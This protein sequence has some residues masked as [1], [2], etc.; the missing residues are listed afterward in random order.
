M[1][2]LPSHFQRILIAGYYATGSGYPNG[3]ITQE[4]L[5][6]ISHVN[7][8]DCGYSMP[9]GT[10]L[11]ESIEK[12]PLAKMDVLWKLLTRNLY[13]A[14]TVLRVKKPG[15]I[16]YVRY[17]GIFFLL[18]MSLVPVKFRP[19]LVADA[20]IS[21]WESWS[22]NRAKGSRIFAK[23]LFS[24]E[25][26]ALTTCTRIIVDTTANPAYIAKTFSIAKEKIEAIP[27]GLKLVQS[28]QPTQN[29]STPEVTSVLFVGTFIPLHGIGVIIE[30]MRLLKSHGDF[31]FKFIGDGAE[32]YKLE[33]AIKSDKD[34]P[35][36]EWIRTWQSPSQL[37]EA[38]THSD[39]CLGIF[40]GDE[41]S[42][43]VLPYKL[44]IYMMLA[45]CVIS[46]SNYSLPA[47]IQ[48]HLPILKVPPD[49]PNALAK[50]IQFLRDN[51]LEREKYS[52][53]A[54][55]FYKNYLSHAPIKENWMRIISELSS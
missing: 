44:Y 13:S 52:I 30:A 8:V 15:D 47:G 43:R 28:K 23:I 55:N 3:E 12:R 21:L 32:A 4:I 31:N 24:L 45:R 20:F 49:D 26:I 48:E 1:T 18:I 11:W 9:P 29:Y 19:V 41:K 51:P 46:Q 17:P 40:S 33:T 53:S 27:L 14:L 35:A 6:T 36:I 22:V 5:G 39:I 42:R 10:K 37:T 2:S 38:I 50:A 54:E 7:V 16:I 34:F 25:K